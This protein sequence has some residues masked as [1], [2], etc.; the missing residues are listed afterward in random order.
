MFTYA[1][2]AAHVLV[3]EGL[4]LGI[5]VFGQCVEGACQILALLLR[6]LQDHKQT[7]SSSTALM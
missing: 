4:N 5:W 1:G 3:A 6:N 2:H 7:M